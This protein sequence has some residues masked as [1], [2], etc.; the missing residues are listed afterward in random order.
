M[1][2]CT[3]SSE[4]SVVIEMGSSDLKRGYRGGDGTAHLAYLFAHSENLE[5]D[6]SSESSFLPTATTPTFLILRLLWPA[7]FTG[8]N[9]P[10]RMG[11][12]R[13]NLTQLPQAA[14]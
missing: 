14:R 11:F 10:R 13:F 6:V 12:T 5:R 8:E 3:G 2:V 4:N 9:N 1:I 7:G